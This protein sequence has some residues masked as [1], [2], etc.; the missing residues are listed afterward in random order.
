MKKILNKN[1]KGYLIWLT[2]VSGSGKSTIAKK[3]INKLEKE[4]GPTLLINGDDIRKIFKLNSFDYKS[5]KETAYKYSELSS[6]ITRQDINVIFATVSM[7]HSV[8]KQN[9]KK[10]KKN[11]VEIFIKSPIKKIIDNRKKKIYFSNKKIVGKD[12]KA[13]FPK[14]PDIVVF[15]DFSK[16]L[17]EISATIT[18][19]ILDKLKK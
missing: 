1:K 10:I 19:K 8:R 15:N 3:I 2:G 12:I 16:S 14:N 9:R 6:F 18:K 11:Y 17:D 13:E 7:F 4:I 5:R